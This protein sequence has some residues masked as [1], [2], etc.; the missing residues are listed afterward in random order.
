M[1]GGVLPVAIYKSTIFL[2]LGQERCNN[3]WSDFG[4]SSKKGEDTFTTAIR[5]GSEELNGYFGSDEEFE[6]NVKKNFLYGIQKQRYISYLFK[7]TYTTNL[8]KY[9][10]NNNRFIEKNINYDILQ[11]KNGLFEK[12]SIKWFSIDEL[13][14]DNQKNIIRPHYYSIIKSICENEDKIINK[15][16]NIYE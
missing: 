4:G 1:G 12:K 7:T 5:E 6:Y 15:I 8:P 11:D 14:N 10:N 16:Y 9:F 3:L 13:K 2:L